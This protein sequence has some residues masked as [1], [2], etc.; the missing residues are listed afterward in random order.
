MKSGSDVES[1]S[2]LY[3][4]N[5]QKSCRRV[6][7]ANSTSPASIVTTTNSLLRITCQSHIVSTKSGVGGQ[8]CLQSALQL[9]ESGRSWR[10]KPTSLVFYFDM[11]GRLTRGPPCE[12][13]SWGSK[14]GIKCWVVVKL[15]SRR[16]ASFQSPSAHWRWLMS[17]F[18]FM[19]LKA[20]LTWSMLYVCKS[21]RPQ[22]SRKWERFQKI[23]VLVQN[24]VLVPKS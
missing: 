9:S 8:V 19:F 24:K 7:G 17:F 6:G 14:W 2:G 1:I 3:L 12:E 4:F 20:K 16:L 11:T 10:S 21:P 13:L 23:I 5:Q 22:D 18:Q 15:A